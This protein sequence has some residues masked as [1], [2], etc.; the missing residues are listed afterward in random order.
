[1]TDWSLG[2]FWSLILSILLFFVAC[3]ISSAVS[4]ALRLR[5]LVEDGRSVGTWPLV[6]PFVSGEGAGST[7]G[8]RAIVI[9]EGRETGEDSGG[10]DLYCVSL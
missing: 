1:M 7:L 5:F 10:S 4:S 3:C 9:S 8:L 2:A 6:A